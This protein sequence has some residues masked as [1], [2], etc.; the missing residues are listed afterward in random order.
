MHIDNDISRVS[1]PRIPKRLWLVFRTKLLQ[2]R[3]GK[4]K[5]GIKRETSFNTRNVPLDISLIRGYLQS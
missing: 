2:L 4:G 3:T 1:L 5:V